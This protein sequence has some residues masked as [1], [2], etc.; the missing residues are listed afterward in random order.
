MR[1]YVPIKRLFSKHPLLLLESI[2]WTREKIIAIFRWGVL[3]IA[4]DLHTRDGFPLR[5]T[6]SPLR[7]RFTNYFVSF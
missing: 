2:E 5:D 4:G 3:K 7:M 6:A 1:S